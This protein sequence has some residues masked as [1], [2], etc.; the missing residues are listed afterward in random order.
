MILFSKAYNKETFNISI[1]VH[2]TGNFRTPV[3]RGIY[4]GKPAQFPPHPPKIL[5]CFC[6]L[7]LSPP[8]NSSVFNFLTNPLPPRG[9]GQ[10]T[11]FWSILFL[12]RKR[13]LTT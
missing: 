10:S 12:K 1:V 13:F 11:I 9:G 3:D 6:G 5:P 7:L 8:S 4:S 2:F